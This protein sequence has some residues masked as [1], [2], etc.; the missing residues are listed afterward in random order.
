LQKL[1]NEFRAATEE[2]SR[3]KAEAKEC[4]DRLALAERLTK[5]LFSEQERWADTVDKLRA[6]EMTI[7]GDVMLAASFVSY[8]GVFNTGFLDHLWKECWLQD[9]KARD[10]PLSAGL[11]PLL[12]LSNYAQMAN[13]QNEGLPSD[14]ISL[15]NGTIV[16]NSSRW[17]KKLN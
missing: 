3:V 14:R 9:L 13:W 11:D 12:L 5:G 10:I 1:Q 2:K 16:T 4:S 7:A 6:K 17:R 8:L 15:E